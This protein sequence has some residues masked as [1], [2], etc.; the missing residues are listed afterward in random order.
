MLLVLLYLSTLAVV[1][2]NC[3]VCICRETTFMSVCVYL[4]VVLVGLDVR[5]CVFVGG[6]GGVKRTRAR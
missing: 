3:P 2:F 4:H 6:L 1:V 5:A